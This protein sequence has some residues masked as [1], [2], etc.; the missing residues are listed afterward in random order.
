MSNT[1]ER[2]LLWRMRRSFEA[3]PRTSLVCK[4]NIDSYIYICFNLNRE[5]AIPSIYMSNTA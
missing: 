4:T 3:C 1:A 2:R 5:T